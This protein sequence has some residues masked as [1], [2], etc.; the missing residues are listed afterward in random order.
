MG[1]ADNGGSAFRKD[2]KEYAT[3]CR[4]RGLFLVAD[5]NAGGLR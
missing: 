1:N 3:F 5:W 4:F 2:A